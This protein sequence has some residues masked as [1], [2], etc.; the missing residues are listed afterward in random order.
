[1]NIIDEVVKMIRNEVIQQSKLVQYIKPF[2]IFT[3]ENEEYSDGTHE[4]R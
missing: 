3:A 4:Q 2:L 1:M